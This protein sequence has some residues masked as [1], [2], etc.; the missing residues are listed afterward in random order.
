MIKIVN[1]LLQLKKN[2]KKNLYLLTMKL[3]LLSKQYKNPKKIN[4]HGNNSNKNKSKIRTKNNTYNLEWNN[5]DNIYLFN[6]I[7]KI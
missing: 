5:D 1:L 3:I 6:Y 2:A 7:K 4:K